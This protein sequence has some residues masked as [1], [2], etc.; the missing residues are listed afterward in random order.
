MWNATLS[1]DRLLT[2]GEEKEMKKTWSVF[3]AAALVALTLAGCASEKTQGDWADPS[4]SA[5]TQLSSRS[6]HGTAGSGDLAG[7]D[8]MVDGKTKPGHTGRADESPLE[9]AGDG[10]R[11]TL[12]DI[13]DAARDMGR[14]AKDMIEGK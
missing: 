12:D 13:G 5:G 1:A 11:N 6:I 4:P 2:R 7:S 8:G 10:I 14:D 3:C 9:R